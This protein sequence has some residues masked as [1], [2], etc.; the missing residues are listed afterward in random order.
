M[1]VHLFADLLHSTLDLVEQGVREPECGRDEVH[2]EERGD[3]ETAHTRDT[4]GLV[5]L[6]HVAT[7]G[8]RERHLGHDG[9]ECLG[10]RACNSP[11]RPR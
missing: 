3:G 11:L 6:G 5:H 1:A 4:H 2:R 9:G 7:D 10:V 8:K